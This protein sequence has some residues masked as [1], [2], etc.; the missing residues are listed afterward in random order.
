MNLRLQ[1]ATDYGS[2]TNVCQLDPEEI[3]EL[4]SSPKLFSRRATKG[5][6]EAALRNWPITTQKFPRQCPLY[7]TNTL[8]AILKQILLQAIITIILDSKITLKSCRFKNAYK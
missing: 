2:T 3:L 5:T 6:A 8:Q 1:E 7:S 4:T